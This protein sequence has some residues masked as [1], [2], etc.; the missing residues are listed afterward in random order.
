MT[1][2]WDETRRTNDYEMNSDI[3]IPNGGFYLETFQ[4]PYKRFH[5]YI[6]TGSN[7]P[8]REEGTR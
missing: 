7:K 5:D 4:M 1:S 6:E 3:E 8:D 2:Q